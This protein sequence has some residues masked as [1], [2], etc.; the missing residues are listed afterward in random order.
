MEDAEIDFVILL[1]GVGSDQGSSVGEEKFGGAGDG[2]A[3][4]GDLAIVTAWDLLE[5]LEGGLLSDRRLKSNAE[6]KGGGETAEN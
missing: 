5:P 1:N 6:A 3:A 2:E 4:C